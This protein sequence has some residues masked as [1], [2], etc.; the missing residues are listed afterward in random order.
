MDNNKMDNQLFN[1]LGGNLQK[2]PWKVLTPQVG[3]PTLLLKQSCL[4]QVKQVIKQPS[5]Q[6][7]PTTNTS[8]HP[9]VIMPSPEM[10]TSTETHPVVSFSLLIVHV[11]FSFFPLKL[12]KIK[13]QV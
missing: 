11:P 3:S 13:L 1:L 4:L 9:V 5:I 2:E 12:N 10:N 7:K 8:I 6:A